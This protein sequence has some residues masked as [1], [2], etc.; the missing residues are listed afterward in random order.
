MHPHLRRRRPLIISLAPLILA[1][2]FQGTTL[3]ADPVKDLQKALQQFHGLPNLDEVDAKRLK[4]FKEQLQATAEKIVR[5]G[6]L[7]RALFLG[8]WR[9]VIFSREVAAPQGEEDPFGKIHQDVRAQ[10]VKRLEK[11][12]R[13]S[14]QAPDVVRRLAAVTFLRDMAM[15]EMRMQGVRLERTHTAIPEL[16]WTP[17]LNREGLS[18]RFT[19]RLAPALSSLLSAKQEQPKLRAAAMRALADIAPGTEKT[20]DALKPLLRPERAIDERRAAAE[21][22][23]RMVHLLKEQDDSLPA[24]FLHLW[25]AA[26]RLVAAAGLGLEDKEGDIR[27][28]CLE[29]I[30]QSARSFFDA[31]RPHRRE[32]ADRLLIRS[33]NE[34]MPAVSRNL[35]RADASVRL[36]AHQ[37][38][39]TFASMRLTLRGWYPAKEEKQWFGGLLDAVPELAKNS[40][41]NADVRTRLAALYVL[42]TLGDAATPAVAQ[43]TQKLKSDKNDFVRWGA[44]R[45]LH[46]LAPAKADEVVSALAGALKDDSDK[47]RLTAV[48][49]LE[50]YGPKAASAVKPIAALIDKKQNAKIRFGAIR[51]LSAIGKEARPA[52]D[53]VIQ[54]LTDSESNVRAAAAWALGQFGDL[55]ETARKALAK[56]L[57]DSD[58]DVR[59]AASDAILADKT[60]SPG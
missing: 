6:D 59:Q 45:A 56:A 33:V 4:Q 10:L 8:E 46:N 24:Q 40:L 39:E 47:V 43:L 11:S 13:S 20:L 51:A 58:S 26:P 17:N 3:A 25:Q 49:A 27:R 57:H 54:A 2:S 14:L 18:G 22:L 38:L 9:G 34:Q 36:A 35:S 19:P 15:D 23:T 29:A 21:S 55:N 60:P 30:H 37:V 41:S 1:I 44:A 16:R 52:T 53:A 5:P 32:A 12:L 50:R 48:A 31:R 28:L 42:E 7:R